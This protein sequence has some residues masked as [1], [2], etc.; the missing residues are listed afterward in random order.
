MAYSDAIWGNNGQYGYTG[1]WTLTGEGGLGLVPT[2]GSDNT[3]NPDPNPKPKPNKLTYNQRVNKYNTRLGNLWDKFQGFEDQIGGLSIN[4][5]WNDPTTDANENPLG[6][7]G[8]RVDHF[9]DLLSEMKF[10]AVRPNDPNKTYDKVDTALYDK[11]VSGFRGL[12]TD[13]TGLRNDRQAAVAD[14]RGFAQN[15]FGNLVGLGRDIRDTGYWDPEKLQTLQDKLADYERLT[16]NNSNKIFDQIGLTDKLDTRFDSMGQR[17]ANMDTRRAEERD[18]IGTFKDDIAGYANLLMNGD[19]L[20]LGSGLEGAAYSDD[21]GRFRQMLEEAY[22]KLGNFSSKLDFDMTDQRSKLDAAQAAYDDLITQR[23][24]ERGRIGDT[25]DEL[26]GRVQALREAGRPE[27]YDEMIA[28]RK[29]INDIL[30]DAANFE[31]PLEWKNTFGL[32]ETYLNDQKANVQSALDRRMTRAGNIEA[33]WNDLRGSGKIEDWDLQG[34]KGREEELLA[35]QERLMG[36]GRGKDIRGF[37]E[38]LA[39]AIDRIQGRVGDVAS[40]RGDIETEMRD[41]LSQIQQTG[42]YEGQGVQADQDAVAALR[43]RIE[44]WGAQQAMD[45]LRNA[46]TYL[47]RE[48]GRLQSDSNAVAERVAAAQEAVRRSLG[49][50]GVPNFREYSL[51]DAAAPGYSAYMAGQNPPPAWNPFAG[52][53]SASLGWG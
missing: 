27:T 51:V 10:D 22:G 47:G 46:E 34:L 17:F 14:A 19:G 23:Q 48:A 53:F 12:G 45:E 36:V 30:R 5:L 4:D 33:D 37:A 18:R 50:G 49:A 1:D 44:Q 8:A 11:L 16:N 39:S 13:I 3:D 24:A 52:S 38:Q 7:L 2:G 25:R 42:Y 32:N 28:R 21:L 29:E 26:R 31:T 35:L 20:A 6:K 15:M 40:T 41:L 9:G 43:S